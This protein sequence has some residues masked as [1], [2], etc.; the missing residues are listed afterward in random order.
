M[1]AVNLQVL[2]LSNN[3]LGGPLPLLANSDEAEQAGRLRIVS[4][5]NNLFEGTI[6]ELGKLASAASVQTVDLRNNKL[7]A[8]NSTWDTPSSAQLL[9]LDGN[10][11]SG[12]LTDFLLTHGVGQDPGTGLTRPQFAMTL[13][14]S[15][16]A[17]WACPLPRPADFPA[18]KDW[19]DVFCASAYVDDAC[20]FDC[21]DGAEQEELFVTQCGIRLVSS[22]HV[23]PNPE[24]STAAAAV[25]VPLSILLLLAVCAAA[26]I[27][28]FK[29]GVAR[30]ERRRAQH[31]HDALL[32]AEESLLAAD[33]RADE[34][35]QMVRELQQP[36]MCFSGRLE[37]TKDEIG[38]G[39]FGTIYK[40]FDPVTGMMLAVKVVKLGSTQET[41][42]RNE[43]MLLETLQHH[44]IVNCFAAEVS[45]Y[46]YHVYYPTSL[47]TLRLYRRLRTGRPS[48]QWSSAAGDHCTA[49]SR[50]WDA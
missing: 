19:Q 40:G 49:L 41:D 18:W 29:A 46:P 25:A 30:R 16:G 10:P 15:S 37:I 13:N 48:L 42:V 35:E 38:Q 43:I 3:T 20:T 31:A 28:R 14:S 17:V 50:P 44:N 2:D 21:V 5:H 27:W 23:Y 1:S 6:S 34:A 8:G 9:L 12:N 33:Q 4:L 45:L 22:C 32:G 26:I 24:P 39:A 47:P 11:F 36:V 7:R